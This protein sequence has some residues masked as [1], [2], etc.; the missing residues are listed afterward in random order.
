M[1]EILQK[2]HKNIEISTI[3][4]E[5]CSFFRF[6]A[7]FRS[8]FRQSAEVKQVKLAKKLRPNSFR[9]LLSSAQ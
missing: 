8:F 4:P 5:I 7:F 3:R 2:V 9:P 1:V 6:T